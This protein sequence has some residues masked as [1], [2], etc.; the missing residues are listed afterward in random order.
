MTESKTK[1]PLEG[2][3]V[4]TKEEVNAMREKGEIAPEKVNN[5]HI[6]PDKTWPSLVRIKRDKG[7]IPN[8]LSG[9]FTNRI[10]AQLAINT[11]LESK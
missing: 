8:A 10:P 5:F 6:V 9:L 2:K 7:A 3:K 4:T 11:Y 1:K